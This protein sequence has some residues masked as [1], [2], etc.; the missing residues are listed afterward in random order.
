[1]ECFLFYSRNLAGIKLVPV[2]KKPIRKNFMYSN[3]ASLLFNVL[4]SISLGGISPLKRKRRKDKDKIA[5]LLLLAFDYD[6]TGTYF[7][8]T[9]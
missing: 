4:A 8:C 6:A 1:M 2:N 3:R 7:V 5:A 9:G